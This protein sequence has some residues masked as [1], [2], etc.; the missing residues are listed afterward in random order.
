MNSEFITHVRYISR[1]QALPVTM[2]SY[3][4][5]IVLSTQMAWLKSEHCNGLHAWNWNSS[6]GIAIGYGLVGWSLGSDSLQGREMFH[7]STASRQIPELTQTPMK[8]VLDP[9]LVW[10]TWLT[11]ARSWPL[12]SITADVKSTAIPSFPHT[13]LW[14]GDHFN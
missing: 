1:R 2:N 9:L 11:G 13:S 10:V 8:R 5:F 6:V 14:Y 12:I 3:T 4:T 7:F